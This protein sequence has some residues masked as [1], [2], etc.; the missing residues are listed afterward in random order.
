MKCVCHVEQEYLQIKG[1]NPPA[2]NREEVNFSHG[3]DLVGEDLIKKCWKKVY[4]D[5]NE[6]L[7]AVEGFATTAENQPTPILPPLFPD[8]LT[9]GDVSA[10]KL[11]GEL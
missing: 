5:M 11:R 9:D 7:E 6:V 1:E 2:V 8:D 10:S 4:S 3:D